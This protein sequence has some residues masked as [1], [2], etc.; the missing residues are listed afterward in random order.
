M[1]FP[2]VIGRNLVAELP[3]FVHR[4]YLVVT[5]ADLWPRFAPLF[6]DHL[7]GVHL[8]ETLDEAVL[9]QL[10]TGLPTGN[11]VIGLGGGQALDVAKYIAWTR[12]LPLFQ[13]P[14]ALTVDAPFGHRAA[15]RVNGNVRYIGWA[16]PEA[17]YID[18]D[19]IQSAPPL[20][21][22]SGIGDILCYHTAH[23]DWDLAHRR[24]KCEAKW[25]YDE[26]LVAEARQ[27]LDGVWCQLDEIHAVSEE[28]IRTLVGGLRYGGATYHN[29][30]WN[31]RHVE[32]VEHF[33][34]YALEALTGK[35]F[36]HGQPVCLG[37]YLGAL[38]QGN[39]ADEV[40]TAIHRVGVDIRP[41]AMGLTWA[42]VAMT[43]RQ[44][45]RYVAANGLWYTI[46]DEFEVTDAFLAEARE[47]IYAVFADVN[48]AHR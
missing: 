9:R 31:P 15:V 19:V 34:F 43:L 26:R 45:R 11:S 29:A 36:I 24:G 38:M 6:D 3:N 41:E 8:V 4:P 10:V 23:F 40:L 20:L 39:R 14:T 35:K 47:R 32:G 30:G 25:P 7:A 42:D 44:L 27:V 18:I 13:V 21:N 2:T 37:V 16:V 46:A 1:E 33:I 5:M 22:R 12:R 28:G 48:I 17:V